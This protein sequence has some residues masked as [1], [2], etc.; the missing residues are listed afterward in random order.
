VEYVGDETCQLCH[1]DKYESF[2]QTGMGMST[3]L[4]SKSGRL[5]EFAKPVTIHK[6]GSSRFYAW[7]SEG[8][9][10]FHRE[11][12]LDASGKEVFSDVRKVVYAV[13]SGDHGRSYLV[14]Q[15]EFLFMSPLSYYSN[16]G[17]WDLSP[18][19]EE[20]HFRGF[21]PVPEVCVFCHTGRSRP[22]SGTLNRYR[23]PPVLALTI[24]CESCH[25]PG[26]LHVRERGEGKEVEG[27]VDRTIVNPSKL[28]PSLRDNV[29]E[30]CHLEGDVRVLRSGKALE[31]FRPGTPLDDVAAIFS[32]PARFK[33]ERF[34]AIGQVEQMK[35]SRCWKSSGG[36]M[37]CITCHDPHVQPRGEEAVSFFKKRCLSFV[38]RWTHFYNIESYQL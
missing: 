13:G 34:R 26:Q 24:G 20:G 6:E 28:P 36:R 1:P 31:D 10:F 3:S 23:D 21:R 19:Y 30:Q 7:W 8:G 32:V 37:A 16:P 29:C 25:G 35:L 18:G 5:S 15:G 12:E 22:V 4:P 2:K 9:E 11:Y 14:R 17:K 27:P 33:G 38:I